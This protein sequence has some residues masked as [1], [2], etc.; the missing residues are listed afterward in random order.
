MIISQFSK[1]C[2]GNILILAHQSKSSSGYLQ[3]IISNQPNIITVNIK[4][5][6]PIHKIDTPGLADYTTWRRDRL[7]VRGALDRVSVWD[8]PTLGPHVVKIGIHLALG[9]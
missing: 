6:V 3:K 1:L 5:N 8:P 7:R 9:F 2:S 4:I